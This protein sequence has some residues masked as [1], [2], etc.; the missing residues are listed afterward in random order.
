MRASVSVCND[1]RG[2]IVHRKSGELAACFSS[3]TRHCA[4]NN[5][6]FYNLNLKVIMVNPVSFS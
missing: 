1:M 2:D 6:G 5:I 4:G 3:E